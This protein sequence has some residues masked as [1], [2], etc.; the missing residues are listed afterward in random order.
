[1]YINIANEILG[2]QAYSFSDHCICINKL[3]N[4]N[5]YALTHQQ[6]V[7]LAFYFGFCSFIFDPFGNYFEYADSSPVN[8]FSFIYFAIY[9]NV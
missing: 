7:D 2:K 8:T 6:Q 9:V 3:I 4:H 5:K 1:M